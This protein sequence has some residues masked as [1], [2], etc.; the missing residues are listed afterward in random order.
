MVE[1]IGQAAGLRIVVAALLVGQ[2]QAGILGAHLGGG[3]A[4]LGIEQ[5]GAGVRRQDARDRFFEFGHHLVGDGFFVHAF[6]LGDGAFQGAALVHGRGANDAAFIRNCFQ[7]PLF[8]RADF[9]PSASK[10]KIYECGRAHSSMPAMV[11]SAAAGICA[12]K[13]GRVGL[14]TKSNEKQIPRAPF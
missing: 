7:A 4:V 2:Q 12:E 9:H 1:Q 11:V 10:E 14:W 5:N 13:D 3:K 6:I 8:A